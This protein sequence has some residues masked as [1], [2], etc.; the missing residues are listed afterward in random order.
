[1]PLRAHWGGRAASHMTEEAEAATPMA[2][3][4]LGVC[5]THAPR[6]S[7]LGSYVLSCFASPKLGRSPRKKGVRRVLL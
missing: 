7:F 4:P 1:M 3:P 6:R 5:R 2:I